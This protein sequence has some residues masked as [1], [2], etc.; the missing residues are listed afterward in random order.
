MGNNNFIMIMTSILIKQL[1]HT[2]TLHQFPLPESVTRPASR[3]LLLLVYSHH[4]L[5]FMRVKDRRN[6]FLREH[7]LTDI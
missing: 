4:L 3:V 7:V 6:T 1:C 5:L 2:H